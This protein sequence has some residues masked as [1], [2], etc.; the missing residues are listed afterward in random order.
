MNMEDSQLVLL[1]IIIMSGM[2]VVLILLGFC[3][4]FSQRK[5][6]KC[7]KSAVTGRITRH[8]FLGGGRMYPVV[9]Y[10]VAEH[11]YTV[12]RKFRGYITKSGMGARNIYKDKGAYVTK[13][14]Y[15][16][17]PMGAVTNLKA[18]AQEL[19]PIGSEMTVY[20]NPLHPKQ[21]YAEKMPKGVSVETIVFLSTGIAF[22][23]FSVMVYAIF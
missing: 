11:T 17:I 21:A 4:L 3:F 9:T 7:C 13:K 5:K 15:L 14:D 16:L 12:A 2:G 22:L 10:Q 19:W 6:V 1:L 23:L 20:F 18:M 8:C